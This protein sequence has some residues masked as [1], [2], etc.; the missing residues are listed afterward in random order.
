M[1]S[2][3]FIIHYLRHKSNF[4]SRSLAKWVRKRDRLV[5]DMGCLLMV[6]L[7]QINFQHSPTLPCGILGAMYNREGEGEGGQNLTKGREVA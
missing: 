7:S 6:H 1:L 2:V 3:S 5:S 4:L